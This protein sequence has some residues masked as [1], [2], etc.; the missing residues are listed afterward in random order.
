MSMRIHIL[1]NHRHGFLND[2]WLFFVALHT[3]CF[4]CSCLAISHNGDIET[5]D[6]LANELIDL[7]T[8]EGSLFGCV[9][10]MDSINLEL[11]DIFIVLDGE[12]VGLGCLVVGEN[13]IFRRAWFDFDTNFDRYT[14]NH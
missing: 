2:A 5:L 8:I 14:L 1:I 13:I 4:A 11:L 12:D 9:C 6:E 10:V 7:Q 3:K